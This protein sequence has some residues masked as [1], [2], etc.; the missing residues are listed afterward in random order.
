MEQVTYGDDFYNAHSQ[1]SISSAKIIIP[2]ILDFIKPNSVIDV[3]CGIGTWLSVWEKLGIADVTGIDGS[4][5]NKENLLINKENFIAVDLE[6]GYISQRTFDIA[7]CLEVAEHLK[8]EAAENLI[9]SLCSMSNFI[10][11]SAAIP[12]QEGLKH[13]NEKYPSYWANLFNKNGFIPIDCIRKKVWSNESVSWWYKQNI[14]IYINQKCLSNFESLQIEALSTDLKFLDL[15]HPEYFNYKCNKVY[16]YER[17]LNNPN[18][19]LR[20]FMK[21]QYAKFIN[22]IKKIQSNN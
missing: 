14:I 9:T 1:M 11:F 17:I 4:Y 16:Y 19:L 20:F 22:R 7:T 15:V 18:K 8:P 5:V 2:I 13:I 21:S 12:G 10:L 6:N 3:G